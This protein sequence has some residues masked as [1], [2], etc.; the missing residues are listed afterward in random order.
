MNEDTRTQHGTEAE[1]ERR[2]PT[3]SGVR[4]IPAQKEPDPLQPASAR[5][6]ADRRLLRG[7]ELELA[8][9]ESMVDNVEVVDTGRLNQLILTD[10]RLIIRGRD[11][12]T[13]YPLRAIMRLAV[14]KYIRWWM[15]V[16]GFALAGVG[17]A[18]AF[19]PRHLI[20][21]GN[22]DFLYVCGGIVL[23][24]LLLTAVALVRPVVYV[25]IKSLGGDMKLHL[26]RNHEALSGFLGS[27]SQRIR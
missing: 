9:G 23:L 4:D 22:I 6:E 24:G 2:E 12:Q 11:H 21:A 26:P 3:F 5:I 17:A 7:Y 18:A 16:L 27:L 10:R 25:E 1:A 8:R 13:V 14:V 15:V 19:L 20:P